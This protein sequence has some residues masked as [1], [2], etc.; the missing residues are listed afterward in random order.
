MEINLRKRKYNPH[1]SKIETNLN[2]IKVRFGSFSSK[3]EDF[4]LMGDFNSEPMEETMSDFM[5]L[6]DLKKL[7]RMPIIIIIFFVF[8]L[9]Q[10]FYIAFYSSY[11]SIC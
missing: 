3:Y 10:K 11:V 9:L 8:F 2:K 6:Y 1:K 7:V 5:E 4:L